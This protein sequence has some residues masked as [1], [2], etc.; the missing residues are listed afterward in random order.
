MTVGTRGAGPLS[1]RLHAVG[2][3]ARHAFT[4]VEL[5]VVVALT[6]L[7]LALL[8]API[9]Q[10]FKLTNKARALAEA[11]DASRFGMERIKRELAQAA[12]VFDNS[13]TP[14][15]LPL[16]DP[17]QPRSAQYP[18]LYPTDAS[19]VVTTRPNIAFA[20]IDFIAAS[21]RAEDPNQ[22]IDPTTNQPVGGAPVVLPVSPSRL[23]VRY[24]VGLRQNTRANGGTLVQ[25][26]YRNVYEFPRTDN[27][28][29]PFVLYRVEYDPRD[30]NMVDPRARGAFDAG[31]INDPNFFY[32]M[33]VADPAIGGNGRTYAENWKNAASPVLG[34]TNLD[35][36]AWRRDTTRQVVAGSSFQ[37]AA[38]FG[39]GAIAGD[40]ATP[41]FTTGNIA[42]TPGAVPSVYTSQ[43]GQWTFPFTVTV[44]RGSTQFGGTRALG[45]EPFGTTSFSVEQVIDGGTGATRLQVFERNRNGSL[46]D[47]RDTNYYWLQD[48][49]TG[50]IIIFTPNLALQIDPTRGRV[51]TS[52]P[53]I[54]TTSTGSGFVPL[55]VPV[56][57]TAQA[58][59]AGPDGNFGQLISLLYRRNTRD[60]DTRG[61]HYA[62][63]PYGDGT[64]NLPINQGIL[65]AN[66]ASQNYYSAAP[67]FGPITLPAPFVSPF[68]AFGSAGTVPGNFRGLMVVPGSEQVLGPDNI[69]SANGTDLILYTYSRQPVRADVLKT[70]TITGVDP[71]RRYLFAGPLQY[72]LENTL[73][74]TVAS[75]HL[76]FDDVQLDVNNGLILDA[77]NLDSFPGIPA[78]AASDSEPQGEVRVS[79]LWQNNYS[80]NSAGEP[81]NPT[82]E[83]IYRG[84]SAD[85]DGSPVGA[86]R[87][88]ADVIKVDYSTRQLINLNIGARVYDSSSGQP[89]T[90][91]VSD[92]VKVGNVSR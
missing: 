73:G 41:G 4:L 61:G 87:P 19:D 56:G 17:T 13:N 20:K 58:M 11:Q 23:Y 43:Y 31:G 76:V 86:V 28:L 92:Q 79:F 72:K 1:T 44:F 54:A 49:A 65:V 68:V 77:T 27:D 35:L 37:L 89:Q 2:R 67:P 9:I 7:L 50:K 59:Q 63:M 5:L 16:E 55:F 51:E 81:V 18:G 52:F 46:V 30:P 29:N 78:R 48:S 32:N 60:D 47:T 21:N 53:P 90:S 34:T 91:S 42:E 39:P 82:G 12:Y 66:L 24:F 64:T 10:G 71:A 84:E 69:L 74:G 25:D 80:R 15:T 62:G 33:N 83:A 75:P 6:A 57:G 38:N 70:R 14:V 88:E 85:R 40:T 45:F 3:K 22:A 26:F 8:F 36:L